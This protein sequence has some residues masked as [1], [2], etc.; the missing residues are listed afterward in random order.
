MTLGSSCAIAFFNDLRASS[1]ENARVVSCSSVV[2]ISGNLHACN[3][4]ASVCVDLSRCV[5]LGR[6][7]S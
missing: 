4:R 1:C 2:I 6:S 5:V 7:K 3:I